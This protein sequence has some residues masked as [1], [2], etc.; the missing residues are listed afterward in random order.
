MIEISS[1]ALSAVI[2]PFGAE[3]SSLRDAEG[4][5][6]MTDA[7][8]AYWTGRAPILFP[9]V[10]A[11]RDDR[12]RANGREYTLPKH[13]FARRMPFEVIEAA[14][15]RARLRLSAND[16]TLRVYPWAFSLELEFEISFKLLTIVARITND[17]PVPMP[18]SFG[19]HPAFAWPLPY[20]RA[21]A[22]H[23]IVFQEDEP[24]TLRALTPDGLIAPGERASPLNGRAL[25][26]ADDLFTNDALIWDPVVSRRVGYGAE[27]GPMLA[28]DFPDAVQLG[29]WTKPGARY[30]CIE[31]WNGIADP[32]GFDGEIWDK[33][34][35]LR[36][37]P[38]AE[39]SFTMLV[40]L[41]A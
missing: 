6:L 2:N 39:R 12:Y 15:D 41:Y 5:E 28:V 26:L 9:I 24:G 32:Q 23:R 19:F 30:V 8:P 38:G 13:G 4:R 1:A 21:R 16:E 33:P 29:I 7:D 35:I 31:P 27:G 11:L 25:N 37:P 34:G 18:A 36:I 14:T 3:L 10:G 17:G 20:G 22:D 40:T